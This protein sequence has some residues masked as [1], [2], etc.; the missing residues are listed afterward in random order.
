MKK[1]DCHN[2]EV[3]TDGV[4]FYCRKCHKLCSVHEESEKSDIQGEDFEDFTASV[5]PTPKVDL[6]EVLKK[7]FHAKNDGD[8][9]GIPQFQHWYDYDEALS[10][11]NKIMVSREA[12]EKAINELP[13]VLVD[14]RF[15]PNDETKLRRAVLFEELKSKLG[16]IK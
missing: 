10:E 3:F 12:V 8:R 4:N 1:S 15:N 2:V 11:I 14:V 7:H 9:G 13:V 5:T 16:L 6:R